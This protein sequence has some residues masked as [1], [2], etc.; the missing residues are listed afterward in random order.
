MKQGV[1]AGRD[2]AATRRMVAAAEALARHFG[3]DAEVLERVQTQK[4][5]PQLRQMLQREAVADLLEAI[6][7]IVCTPT[8]MKPAEDS[9]KAQIE[10]KKITPKRAKKQVI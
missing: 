9:A 4:G 5:E 1:L 10:P 2:M 3:L 8:G 7:D 6:A